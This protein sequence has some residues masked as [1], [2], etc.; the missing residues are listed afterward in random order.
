VLPRLDDG[1]ELPTEGGCPRCGS[2]RMTFRVRPSGDTTQPRSA[3]ALLWECRECG[4]H[5]AE[6]MTG[7]T[8]AP[9]DA[10]GAPRRLVS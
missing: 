7:Q 10:P 4:L 2:T 9:V 5:W 3:R 6:A 8:S 1:D